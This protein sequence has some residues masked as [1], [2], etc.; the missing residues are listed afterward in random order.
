MNMHDY[1]CVYDTA[2]KRRYNINSQFDDPFEISIKYVN[3]KKDKE[4]IYQRSVNSLAKEFGATKTFS[5]ELICVSPT[6]CL[7]DYDDIWMTDWQS[8]KLI[9]QSMRGN[10]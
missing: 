6:V 7:N 10:R 5:G 8:T 3:D 9:Y 2:S 4:V 1:Y